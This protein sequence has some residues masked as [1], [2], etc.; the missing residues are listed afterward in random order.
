MQLAD[1]DFVEEGKAH[2][3]AGRDRDAVLA[4]GNAIRFGHDKPRALF[5]RANLLQRHGQMD[6]A[7]ADY[8][9]ALALEPGWAVVWQNRGNLLLRAGR[10]LQGLESLRQSLRLDPSLTES[11]VSMGAALQ[12]LGRAEEAKAAYRSVLERVP[13]HPVACSNLATLLIDGAHY[14][15]AVR[16]CQTALASNPGLVS[17]RFNLALALS[18][19][20]R[21]EESLAAYRDTVAHDP[22]HARAWVNLGVLLMDRQEREEALDCFEKARAIDPAMVLATVNAALMH[23]ELGNEAAAET[24]LATALDRD[25][26]HPVANFAWMVAAV[27]AIPGADTVDKERKAFLS[28]LEQVAQTVAASPGQDF[29]GAVGCIQPY[30]LAYRDRDNSGLLSRYGDLCHAAMRPR[31]PAAVPSA[32][33]PVRD[34]RIHVGFV[35][36]HVREHSVFNAITLGYLKA[37]DRSRFRVSVFAIDNSP[38]QRT[39]EARAL[40]DKWHDGT[41]PLQ[42]WITTLARNAPDVLVY[43]EIGMDQKTL[44]LASLRLAPAQVAC[45]GHPET[46]GLP[47]IDAYLSAEL[48]EDGDADAHYREHLVRLPNLGAV[49]EPSAIGAVPVD[50]AGLGETGGRPVFVCPGAAFKYQPEYDHIYPDIVERLG[51]AAFFFFSMQRKWMSDR[52]EARLRT[53]FSARGHEFD[54]HCHMLGWQPPERFR[55]ILKAADACLDT[56]GFSGFNTALHAVEAGTPYVAFEGTF[57]RG[58][59]GSAVMQRMGIDA[60]VARNTAEFTAIAARLAGDL[61]FAAAMRRDIERERARLYADRSVASALNAAIESLHAERSGLGLRQLSASEA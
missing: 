20:G 16:L 9:Q 23:R 25:P 61:E 10:L 38:D 3:R 29:S 57:M 41:R 28:R 2:E 1:L 37:L 35:S 54:A 31:Q 59:L 13:R 21:G 36:A 42:A 55:G 43:P 4:Y 8:D 5:A 19:L 40:A 53:T 51:D 47:T 6:Q 27:P 15:E 24:L 11:A 12:M 58:R 22:R 14:A 48:F 7:L 44:Q 33:K 32:A 26:A 50:L 18:G 34:G 56:I 60:L 30:Y 39:D 49:I 17:A 45:W 46:T 52:F